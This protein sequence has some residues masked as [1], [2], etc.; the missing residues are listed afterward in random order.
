MDGNQLVREYQ[1][2]GLR[3]DRLTPG[4]VDSY[5]GDP[6]LR[7]L[8]DNESAPAPA[9]LAASAR[10]LRRELAG[11]DL[12]EARR[13]FLDAHLAALECAGRKLAGEPIGFVDEVRSYFQTTITPGDQDAYRQ[14]HADLD[15]VL[16]GGGPLRERLADFRARDEI[17]PRRLAGCV[18]AVSSAL[19][20]RVRGLVGLPEREIVEYQ[21]VADKPWSG[22]NYYLGDFRS[23]VAIN[24]DV[25]HRMSNLPHLVAHESYPGHHTEHCRK[26]AGL[27]GALGHGEQA[28]FLLNTPQCLVAEGLADLG[29]HAVVG[30]GWGAWTEGIMADLGLWMDGELAETVE[31]A[32]GALLSVR[33]DAA[34]LLH[35]RGVDQDDVI[36]YLCRWLLVPPRRA[37]QLLRFVADPLWRAYTTTYVEGYRLVRAWLD[38]RPAGESLIERYRRLLDEPLVPI[39]LREEI[40]EGVR[41]LPSNGRAGCAG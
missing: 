30:A 14:A 21:V 8:V 26:D 20:D 16:P 34:L 13:R 39:T 41:W 15:A 9:A 27:V 31:R 18:H 25:G 4:V 33:Q 29:L 38:A 12:A 22:F 2:L 10:S 23:R 36:E 3:F 32:A 40:S 7:R 35:D 19:R 1:L 11:A 24:A 28:I 5:T 17:P 6:A 37:R